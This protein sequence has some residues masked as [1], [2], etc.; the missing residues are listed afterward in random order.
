[1]ARGARPGVFPFDGGVAREGEGADHDHQRDDRAKATGDV[2][3]NGP[4]FHGEI[5]ARR[6]EDRRWPGPVNLRGRCEIGSDDTSWI[7]V[8]YIISPPRVITPHG[9]IGGRANGAGLLR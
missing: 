8:C 7:A 4:V 5:L 3:A 6:R 2:A 9:K 1:M